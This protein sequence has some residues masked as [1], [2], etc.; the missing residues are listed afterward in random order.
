MSPAS[1]IARAR[2]APGRASPISYEV[3]RRHLADGA[4]TTLHLLVCDLRRVV[5][6]A[7]VLSEHET[8]Q[9][10]CARSGIGDAIVGGFFVRPETVPLGELRINGQAVPSVPFSQPWDSVR[11]SVQLAGHSVRIARRPA[12]EDSPPGDLIQAGPLLVAGGR[13]VIADGSDAEGFSAAAH[14]F[15]SDITLGRHPRAALG[16]AGTRLVAAVCEGR[17]DFEAGMTLDELADAMLDLGADTA[18]NL[19]GGGSASLVVRGRLINRPREEHGLEI[20]GG[21]PIA[22]AIAFDSRPRPFAARVRRR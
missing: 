4:A 15:D 12:F 9:G 22:T 2:A 17:A 18:I 7:V 6:R 8:L 1:L 13:R 19:D 3:H 14:Q 11:A 21:R 10:W 16:V 20:L 5:P